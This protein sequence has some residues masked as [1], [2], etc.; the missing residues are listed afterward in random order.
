MPNPHL[1]LSRYR[2]SFSSYELNLTTPNLCI[3]FGVGSLM[4]IS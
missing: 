3:G 1:T 2:A 4:L